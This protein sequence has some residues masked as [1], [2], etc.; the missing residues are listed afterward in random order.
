MNARYY[1][2]YSLGYMTLYPKFVCAGIIEGSDDYSEHCKPSYFCEAANKIDWTIDWN[3]PTSLTNLM[4]KYKM[5]CDSSLLIGAF[6]SAYFAGYSLGSIIIPPI[7]DKKGRKYVFLACHFVQAITAIILIVLPSAHSYIYVII[8][9]FLITGMTSG[10][11]APIGFIMM[12]D[13]AQKKHRFVLGT[14][15]S[16]SEH[17]VYILLTV[18]FK[19]MDKDWVIPEIFGIV[20]GSIAIIWVMIAPE[21]AKW[22]FEKEMYHECL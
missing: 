21:S 15:K 17:T 19:H 3:A 10:G 12:C 1:V 16:F 11:L 6:G 4:S 8:F 18:Y 5:Y 9:L 22:L 2:I 7:S 14:I 20:T 13:F